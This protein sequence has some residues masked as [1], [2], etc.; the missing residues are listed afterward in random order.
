MSVE[1]LIR[2][3]PNVHVCPMG[4]IWGRILRTTVLVRIS[5]I[6]PMAAVFILAIEVP[7]T[8]NH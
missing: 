7:K 8:H 4:S 1:A 3:P 6:Q 2:I 5:K